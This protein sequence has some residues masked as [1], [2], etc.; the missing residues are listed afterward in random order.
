MSRTQ[1]GILRKNALWMFAGQ[2][3]SIALQGVYFIF[4]ARVLGVR[5]YGE[6]V[7]AL[8]FVSLLSQYGSLGMGFVFLRHVSQDVSKSR[9]Y[10][11]NILIASSCMSA[12]LVC[13][14]R[15]LAPW[16][17]GSTANGFIVYVAVSE[18]LFAQLTLCSGQVFQALERMRSTAILNFSSNALRAL[19]VLW[20]WLTIGSATAQQWAMLQ[21]GL[22]SIAV[23]AAVATV[24]IVIG[25]PIFDPR[26]AFCH[27]GEGLTFAIS[28]S[29]TSAYNDIDKTMLTHYHFVAQTG[30]Y[31][32]AYRIIDVATI[33]IRSIQAAA[34]PILCRL[35]TGGPVVTSEYASRL[36][37][38]TAA[39]GVVA[40]V[41]LLLFSPL[42][43]QLV[44]HKFAETITVVQWLAVIPLFRSFHL[45]AGD[46][47][48]GAGLQRVRLANQSA[49]AM[50]NFLL[51]IYAIP[52]GGWKGAAVVSL[53]TDGY[54][55]LSSWA[56][57]NFVGRR[58]RA[59]ECGDTSVI[60][61]A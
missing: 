47:L 43:P 28:G 32:M 61:G 51:N 52:L 60:I 2:G 4:L 10:W 12:A 41:G 42:L 1:Q 24:T 21:F 16:V 48:A 55:A 53:I 46:A 13:L 18:C 9:K 25:T 6:Y 45:A 5:E 54:L 3:S 34:F 17:I 36:L 39:L 40:G 35:G 22:S 20:L 50:G 57:L 26:E 19:A 11:G 56:I 15:L 38:R 59:R 29:T 27:A 8:A 23:I 31:A 49:A 44:G 58:S 7:G 37:K 14:T 33:P 30:I